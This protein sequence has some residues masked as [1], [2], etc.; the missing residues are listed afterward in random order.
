MLYPGVSSAM[1]TAIGQE[2]CAEAVTLQLTWH[3]K[4]IGVKQL[5]TQAI[6]FLL[7]HLHTI[8]LLE[9]KV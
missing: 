8:C 2:H 3:R 4:V 1:V 7:S 5:H 9:Q 6:A